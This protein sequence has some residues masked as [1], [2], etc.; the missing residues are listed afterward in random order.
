MTNPTN[1]TV[2]GRVYLALRKKAQNEGRSTDEFLQLHA[3]EA[4][5]DRL[6]TSSRAQDFVLKGGVLLSAYDVRRPTRDVDLASS[7][8]PNAPAQVEAIVDVI[9]RSPRGDGW[10]LQAVSSES[11]RDDA[12]YSGVRVTVRGSLASARQEFH[13][14]I[15]IGDPIVPAPR[16]VSLERLLGGSITLRG[17]P[18]EMVLAEKLVTALQRGA[19]NTRWRDYADLF[20]LSRVHRVDA[21]TLLSSVERVL[22]ARE[23]ELRTLTA[24]TGGYGAAAQGK[25]AAWTRKQKL[26]DRLPRKF[27]ELLESIATFAD[28]LLEKRISGQ[29]WDPKSPSWSFGTE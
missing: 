21:D 12:S 4:F 13:V 1:E 24:A 11:I 28:P 16:P 25:W 9:A 2:A 29:T 22:E 3:L 7:N 15:S 27:R 17:Y 23:A 10:E 6:A 14:D 5:V 18:L 19:T 26:E 20:F 8:V